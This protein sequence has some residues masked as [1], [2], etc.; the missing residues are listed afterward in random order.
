MKYL[1]TFSYDGSLFHGLERQ[2]NAK[3][4]QGTLENVLSNLLEQ[5]V[6]I[7]AS[8][9]TDKGV[10]ALNQKAHF[11]ID[12]KIPMG[13]KKKVNDLLQDEIHIKRIKKVSKNFH[14]RF[15]VKKKKYRYIINLDKKNR[16]DAYMF[17][18]FY[19]LDVKKMKKASKVFVGTHDFKNF[20]SGYREDYKTHIYNIHVKKR[21][22]KIIIDFLGT[23]FFRYMVRHLVGALYDVGRGKIEKE[24]ILKMLNEPNKERQLTVMP[25]NGLYLVYVKY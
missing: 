16:N 6:F 12:K 20:T 17:T 9:R 14:A 7:K 5:E 13:F 18:C 11:V 8:G 23:G 25:A 10:H 15:D 24:D 2:K 21:K 19:K 1:I 3:S 4:I 22:G